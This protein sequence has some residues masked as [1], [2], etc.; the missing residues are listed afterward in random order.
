MHLSQPFFPLSQSSTDIQTIFYFTAVVQARS[1]GPNLFHLVF[2]G[3]NGESDLY[4]TA[5]E[6]G[7]GIT[8]T[9]R[10]FIITND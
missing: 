1:A 4:I 3:T 8:L 10:V 5:K 9:V 6:E 7:Q 2:R